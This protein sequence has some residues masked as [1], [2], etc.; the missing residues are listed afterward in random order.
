MNYA[1]LLSGG[2][3]TRIDSNIPKQYIRIG[4]HMMMTYVLKTM[5]ES[6]HI[7]CVVIAAADSWRNDILKDISCVMP[8][9]DKIAGFTDPG[10]TRQ[11]S[12]L[13]GLE[14]IAGHI[15]EARPDDEAVT[16]FDTAGSQ[17]KSADTV[18]IHDAARP[19]LSHEL[20]DRCYGSLDG[21]DGVMPVLPMKDTVYLSQDGQAVS[22]LLNRNE[23]YAGQA[24]ELF[25]LQKYLQANRALLPD[26]IKAING[27]SEPAV[28][29]GMNIHMISGDEHN[30]KV[31]TDE[32][33]KKSI[34]DI[35][36]IIS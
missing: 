4:G 32:D 29:Y 20:I 22:E 9:V 6:A 12:I 14:Y 23:I 8:S 13:N 11:L 17:I 28:M 19:F 18:L 16:T 30:Y 7:E 35:G 27:A 10:S 31:T 33:L 26:R 15:S 24:P 2:K 21:Y 25:V 36:G 3:G 5:L 34:R 1:I